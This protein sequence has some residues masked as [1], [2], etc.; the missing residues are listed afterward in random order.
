MLTVIVRWWSVLKS[1]SIPVGRVVQCEFTLEELNAIW[2]SLS[3]RVMHLTDNGDDYGRL[4]RYE[5]TLAKV[6]GF[7]DEVVQRG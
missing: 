6:K 5:A 1:V 7:M 2:V 4:P 3:A